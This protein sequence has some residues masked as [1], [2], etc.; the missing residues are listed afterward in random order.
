MIV[1]LDPNG[2]CHAVLTIKT[3]KGEITRCRATKRRRRC[4]GRSRTA[5]KNRLRTRIH[6]DPF[7]NC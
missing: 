1:L 6:C 5:L 4:V 3:G 7:P 2:A